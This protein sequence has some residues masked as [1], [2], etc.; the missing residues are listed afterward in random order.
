MVGKIWWFSF[1]IV[2]LLIAEVGSVRAIEYG[3]M[4]QRNGEWVFRSTED[5]VLKL[6]R[7]KGVITDERYNEVSAQKGKNW[8]EPADA[9]LNRRQDIEWSRYLKTALHLPDW[10]DLGLENR[11]RF[12][13]YDHPWRS[14][15]RIGHGATDS[16][17][18]L[19][20][21]VRVGLGGN[22]PFRFL[23]E[24]QDSRALS[25]D[26]PGDFRTNTTIDQFDITQLFGALSI[27]NV[28]GSGLRTDL[29]FGRMT[30]DF[31]NR[32]Y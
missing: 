27:N 18:L 4:V 29:H 8:I 19:R 3:E 24:G 2:L 25:S 23:F 9:I 5:P 13:S 31:G 21:R 30:M 10:I 7:D 26:A 1:L 15:Q 32:R 22:G 6:M 11:S 16:Q 28:G 12:E 17:L 14:N 20:D